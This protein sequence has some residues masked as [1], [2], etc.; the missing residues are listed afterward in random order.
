[1]RRLPPLCAAVLVLFAGATAAFA[2]AQDSAPRLPLQ[3]NAMEPLPDGCRMTVVAQNAT[4]GELEALTVEVAVFDAN[5]SVSRLLRLNFGVLIA[6]KTRIRQ[7]DLA[8]T[9]CE[10]VSRIIVN[11]V[12]TC[13]GPLEPLACLRAID[14]SSNIDIGFGL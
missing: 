8:E 5:G 14:A 12:A 2:Q 4:G 6:D 7:F 9:S 11:D 3:L 13:E 10:N 1:M